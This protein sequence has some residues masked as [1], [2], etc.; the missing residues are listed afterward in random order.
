MGASIL[1][2]KIFNPTEIQIAAGPY[3]AVDL[4]TAETFKQTKT[5]L[6]IVGFWFYQR[7]FVLGVTRESALTERSGISTRTYRRLM[8]E[9]RSRRM[10]VTSA[11]CHVTQTAVLSWPMAPNSYAAAADLFARR[12]R[13]EINKSI[14]VNARPGWKAETAREFFNLRP[15]MVQKSQ[16]FSSQVVIK[17]IESGP[18]LPL[19]RLRALGLWLIMSFA[20]SHHNWEGARQ[21]ARQ[22]ALGKSRV[23][24]LFKLLSDHRLIRSEIGIVR[25]L[26]GV[27]DIRE[28]RIGTPK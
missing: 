23:I 13:R 18:G 12:V 9:L 17:F 4:S 16:Q 26:S 28:E 1:V 7:A 3:F 8:S 25:V 10:A 20:G 11:Y 15:T 6:E 14:S 5:P 2:Q 19:E 22:L 21:T 27:D 24:G